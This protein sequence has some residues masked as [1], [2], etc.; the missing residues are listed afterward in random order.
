M[1]YCGQQYS[2]VSESSTCNVV[3]LLVTLAMC[4]D[5][6]I[7]IKYSVSFGVFT[8]ISYKNIFPDISVHPNYVFLLFSDGPIRCANNLIMSYLD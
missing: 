4:S 1:Q 7:E 5:S 8:Y 6:V 2:T 3:V